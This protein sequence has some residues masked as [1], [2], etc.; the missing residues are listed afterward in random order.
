M[1][2]FTDKALAYEVVKGLENELVGE[3]GKCTVLSCEL[4]QFHGVDFEVVLRPT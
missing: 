3:L 2:S 1:K 4:L